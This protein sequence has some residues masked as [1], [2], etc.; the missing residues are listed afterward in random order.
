MNREIDLE[1]QQP[2]QHEDGIVMDNGISGSHNFDCLF[3]FLIFFINFG[4]K[5][6]IIQPN[7]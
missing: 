2:V 7:R 4:V 1:M 5:T 3:L 6:I